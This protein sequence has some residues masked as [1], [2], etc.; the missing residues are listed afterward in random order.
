MGPSKSSGRSHLIIFLLLCSLAAG[1]WAM[2]QLMNGGQKAL[3]SMHLSSD[4]KCAA[5][6]YNARY[7]HFDKMWQCSLISDKLISN[8]QGDLYLVTFFNPYFSQ[9]LGFKMKGILFYNMANCPK[10]CFKH[11]ILGLSDNFMRKA[12]R[13]ATRTDNFL[14]KCSSFFIEQFPLFLFIQ[15]LA[16]QGNEQN[17]QCGQ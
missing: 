7:W 13:H 17:V 15:I 8:V 2:C 5:L 16:A 6:P 3:L 9:V 12:L 11:E 1:W 14:W 4:K 10:F